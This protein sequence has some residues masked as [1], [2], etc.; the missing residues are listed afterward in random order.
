MSKN[1]RL[2]IPISE[3]EE[4]L[5]KSAARRAGLPLAAWARSVLR[6][7]ATQSGS[8]EDLSPEEILEK[9]FSLNAP[10]DSIEKMIEESVAGR[11][12]EKL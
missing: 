10:I 6:E 4:S 3:A 2:Q 12:Q 7:K 11:Y 8:S 1:K 9:M 5:L